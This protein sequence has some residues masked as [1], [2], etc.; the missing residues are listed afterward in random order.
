MNSDNNHYIR[1]LE[2]LK[3]SLLF[4]NLSPDILRSFLDQM[5]YKHWKIGTIKS[6]TD[7]EL[8]SLNFI[9]SG[10]LKMYQIN[11]DSGR[12]HTFF[13]L[14]KGDIFDV[15]RLMDNDVH[16]VYWEAIDDLELLSVPMEAMRLWI[17]KYPSLNQSI[18]Y[19]LG[20]RMRLLE[21]STADSS[22]HNTL[23][24]L[25]KLLLK[26]ING[27][28]L[29]LELVNNLSN[30]E[31]AS[32]IG[33]TRAVVNRHIQELKKCDAISVKRK[34][35]DIKNIQILLSIAEDKHKLLLR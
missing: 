29:K 28:S 12:E 33:T 21:S 35:I 7:S 17:T 11:V 14:S 1:Y 9:I 24:R 6:G 3:D 4:K 19:Y 13:I 18:L 15:L 25:S 16:I 27:Q 8:S 2:S 22:L 23:I 34:Q 5:S 30:E 26:N 10:R 32:L 31:L 20:K